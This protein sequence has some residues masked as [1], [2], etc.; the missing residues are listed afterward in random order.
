MMIMEHE[1]AF[2]CPNC[3]EDWMVVLHDWVSLHMKE[4]LLH[5][6]NCDKIYLLEYELVKFSE[7]CK[8]E[9]KDLTLED[10]K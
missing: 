3:G 5:C 9:L 1:E 7:L 10:Y 2:I 4:V 8:T 6:V